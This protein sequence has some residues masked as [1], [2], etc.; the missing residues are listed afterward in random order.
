M[1]GTGDRGD[2]VQSCH[3]CGFP[4][5]LGGVFN[6]LV[7]KNK[8]CAGQEEEEEKILI[9]VNPCVTIFVPFLGAWVCRLSSLLC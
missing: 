7:D 3:V 9:M 6:L 1:G 2:V 8:G 4:A 5:R